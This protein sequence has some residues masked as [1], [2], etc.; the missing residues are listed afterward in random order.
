MLKKYPNEEEYPY[1]REDYCS[2]HTVFSKFYKL[3]SII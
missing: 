2:I 3:L 1:I